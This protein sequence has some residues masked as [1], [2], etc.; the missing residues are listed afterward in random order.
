MRGWTI[1]RRGPW[2]KQVNSYVELKGRLDDFLIQA[3]QNRC[4]EICFAL[5]GMTYVSPIST[6]KSL[7]ARHN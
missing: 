4:D 5:F 7:K 1:H 6:M 2:Q 3:K